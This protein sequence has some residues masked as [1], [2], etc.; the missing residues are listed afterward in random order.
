MIDILVYY[1]SKVEV[2]VIILDKEYVKILEYT[3]VKL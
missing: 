1:N 3:M 2:S